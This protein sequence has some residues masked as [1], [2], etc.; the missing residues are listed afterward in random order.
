MEPAQRIRLAVATVSELRQAAADD[1]ALGAAIKT[2][3]CIQSQRFAGTYADLLSGSRY[4]E[5]ARFFL[6]ELYSESDYTAR[7]AQ[8]ARIAGAMQRLLPHHA[9][10]TAVALAELHVLTEQLDHDMAQAWLALVPASGVEVPTRHYIAAWQTVTR[11]EDRLA[12]LNGVLDI[13]RELDRLTRLPGLRMMLKM[14]RGPAAAAGLASLQHF[15]ETGFDTFSAMAR[16]SGG[17]KG[18]LELIEQR[19]SNWIQMLFEQS[20]VT[21]E[22]ELARTLSLAT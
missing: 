11:R 1:S 22:L 5:A 16:Q 12:Q 21:C 3:K 4:R 15:L 6:D 7:D 10:A 19:E 17:V 13:G 18:F 8:F 9:V 20:P 2:V 14:M